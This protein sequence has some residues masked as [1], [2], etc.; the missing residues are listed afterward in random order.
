[1]EDGQYNSNGPD[2]RRRTSLSERCELL[3]LPDVLLAFWRLQAGAQGFEERLLLD[4]IAR[5]RGDTIVV[6]ETST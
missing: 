2:R 1:M 5:I 6:L 3:D 4:G